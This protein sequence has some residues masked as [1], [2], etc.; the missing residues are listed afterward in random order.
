MHENS[1][2]QRNLLVERFAAFYF[3]AA[4]H[5]L[6]IMNSALRCIALDH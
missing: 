3:S 4:S 6:K 1:P 2:K 5:L